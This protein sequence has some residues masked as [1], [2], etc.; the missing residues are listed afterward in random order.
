MCV[1]LVGMGLQYI[2]PKKYVQIQNPFKE[3]NNNIDFRKSILLNFLP[4]DKAL[5]WLEDIIYERFVHVRR[6]K[7]FIFYEPCGML[8][9]AKCYDTE[10]IQLHNLI[11]FK[12][13]RLPK[14][15]TVGE[16]S[17]FCFGGL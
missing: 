12:Q 11:Y 8:N 6:N 15:V 17:D 13:E 4:C 1:D 2:P 10:L 7:I 5:I 14:I 16:L 9:V 3:L